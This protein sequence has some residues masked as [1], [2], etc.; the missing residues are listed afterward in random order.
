MGTVPCCLLHS[1]KATLRGGFGPSEQL[2]GYY[3]SAVHGTHLIRIPKLCS[4]NYTN[5]WC[6]Q[7]VFGNVHNSAPY[8]NRGSVR[9]FLRNSKYEEIEYYVLQY[10]ARFAQQTRSLGA[11]GGLSRQRCTA[12]SASSGTDTRAPA[13]CVRYRNRGSVRPSPKTPPNTRK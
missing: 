6:E 8:S 4:G 10:G 13:H 11:A 1:Y 5:Q 7:C 12:R 3:E 2:K 9:T